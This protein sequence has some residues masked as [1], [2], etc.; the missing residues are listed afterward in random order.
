[1]KVENKRPVG[2]L[3]PLEIQEWKWEHISMDFV[4]GL[5]RSPRGKDAISVVVDRLT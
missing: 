1:M 4:V 2:L 5:P 3:Q